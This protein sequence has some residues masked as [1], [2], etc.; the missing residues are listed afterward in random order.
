MVI[1]PNSCILEIIADLELNSKTVDLAFSE[2]DIQSPD[3]KKIGEKLGIKLKGHIT[4]HILFEGWKI[5]KSKI[6]W[7]TLAEA[8]E[9]IER[10]QSAAKKARQKKGIM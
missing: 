7:K 3:W 1:Y 10:Y 9:K 6:S 4:A 8:L 2:A 5:H